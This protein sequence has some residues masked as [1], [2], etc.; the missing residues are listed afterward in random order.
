MA[1][2]KNTNPRSRKQADRERDAWADGMYDGVD[3]DQIGEE[4]EAHEE[5]NRKPLT[6]DDFEG[7]V[8][9]LE[10]PNKEKTGALAASLKNYGVENYNP[11]IPSVTRP[12]ETLIDF[13][14]D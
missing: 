10:T 11:E 7:Y 13:I 12:D 1:K 5:E 8:N 3:L 2:A 14:I 4:A 9:G 6:R